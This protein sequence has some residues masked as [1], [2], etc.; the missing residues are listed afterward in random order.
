MSTDAVTGLRNWLAS[1]NATQS[2]EPNVDRSRPQVAPAP[3][4]QVVGLCA[5]CAARVGKVLRNG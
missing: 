3:P 2:G 5:D 1:P 4:K